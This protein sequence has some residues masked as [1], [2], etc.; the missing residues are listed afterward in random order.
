MLFKEKQVVGG[1]GHAACMAQVLIAHLFGNTLKETL[2]AP[3]NATL[4]Q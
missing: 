3:V 4:T 1:R 2:F